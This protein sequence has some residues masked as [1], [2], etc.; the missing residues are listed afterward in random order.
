MACSSFSCVGSGS[1]GDLV[2]SYLYELSADPGAWVAGSFLFYNASATETLSV[3][4]TVVFPTT[5]SLY[6][7][8][9]RRGHRA[10]EPGRWLT[11]SMT[12]N[13]LR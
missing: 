7:A 10:C 9:A 6:D 13:G 4:A 1:E 8:D 2:V 11:W 5:G 12:V 3:L